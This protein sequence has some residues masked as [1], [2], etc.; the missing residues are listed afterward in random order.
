MKSLY[1]VSLQLWGE[2]SQADGPAD[3]KQA[4]LSHNGFGKSLSHVLLLGGKGCCNSAEQ[5]KYIKNSVTKQ[6]D[7]HSSGLDCQIHPLYTVTA[8]HSV[9][10]M[11]PVCCYINSWG[12][13][14]PL[15]LFSRRLGVL[16][17]SLILRAIIGTAN[18]S[19]GFN[20]VTVRLHTIL[21]Q[22]PPPQDIEPYS[23]TTHA[24]WL[25]NDV[26]F[27]ANAM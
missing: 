3:D 21:V 17:Q 27:F 8:K 19:V 6:Q 7:P 10:D 11:M 2:D 5:Q 25:H 15:Y 1:L 23:T 13:V 4:L 16:L 22:Q 24:I 14:W 12:D 26:E 20:V 9:H 18:V